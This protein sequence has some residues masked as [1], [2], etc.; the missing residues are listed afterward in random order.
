MT[1]LA[2]ALQRGNWELA[3]LCLL[4]GIVRHASRLP[5]ETLD[6]LLALLEPPRRGP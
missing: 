1:L 5:S 4:L 2:L 3:T 6:E